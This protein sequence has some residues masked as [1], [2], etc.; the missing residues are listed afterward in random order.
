MGVSYYIYY[1]CSLS[2]ISQILCQRTQNVALNKR[3]P[4]LQLLNICRLVM[5][6]S[7][8]MLKLFYCLRPSE[9]DFLEGP[10]LPILSFS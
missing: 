2:Y 9:F 6:S 5:P 3:P 4:G 8:P 7:S 1:E 10:L